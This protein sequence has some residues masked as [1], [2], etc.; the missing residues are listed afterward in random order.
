MQQSPT[1]DEKKTSTTKASFSTL[2][3]GPDSTIV[4]KDDSRLNLEEHIKSVDNSKGEGFKKTSS[5]APKYKIIEESVTQNSPNPKQVEKESP[6]NQP[7]HAAPIQ[8]KLS[9]DVPSAEDNLSKLEDAKEIK[10]AESTKLIKPVETSKHDIESGGIVPQE[11]QNKKDEEFSISEVDNLKNPNE[12]RQSV[13]ILPRKQTRK[14]E[15]DRLTDNDL[16]YLLEVERM[17]QKSMTEFMKCFCNNCM[18]I[19]KNSIQS[20]V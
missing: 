3:Q 20:K 8:S 6:E 9:K 18:E 4:K 19:V 17:K 14:K 15:H 1:N 16:H 5:I 11:L 10:K 7:E 2:T 12:K 13:G